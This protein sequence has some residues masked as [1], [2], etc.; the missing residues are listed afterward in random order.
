MKFQLKVETETR[1]KKKVVEDWS[2]QVNQLQWMNSNVIV[3]NIHWAL[4]EDAEVAK[5]KQPQNSKRR[6]FYYGKWYKLYDFDILA[7]V[8]SKMTS[9][10]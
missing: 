5:V 1:Q 4:S 9:K 8:T 3:E 7:L 10:P 2:K 6:K